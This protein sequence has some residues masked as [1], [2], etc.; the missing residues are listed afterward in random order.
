MEW[1]NIIYTS[2][3]FLKSVYFDTATPV[4]FC[5]GS[6]L[7]YNPVYLAAILLEIPKLMLILY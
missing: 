4:H 1:Y 6:L 7:S 5:T 3:A 2:Q